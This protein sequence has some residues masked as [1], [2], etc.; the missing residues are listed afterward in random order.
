M[1]GVR[2]RIMA[3]NKEDREAMAGRGQIAFDQFGA[4]G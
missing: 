2:V 3:V 4:V 1:L